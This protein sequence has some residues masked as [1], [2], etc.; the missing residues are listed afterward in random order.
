M[1]N[2]QAL[3]AIAPHAMTAAIKEPL[4]T[5]LKK[6]TKAGLDINEMLS[7]AHD[8]KYTKALKQY[9]AGQWTAPSEDFVR[10]MTGQVYDGRIIASVKEQFVD[11]VRRALPQFVS[12]RIS[13]R[14]KSALRQE[15]VA[16]EHEEAPETTEEAPPLDDGIVTTEEELEGFHVVRA[17]LREVVEVSRITHRDVKSYFGILLDDNNRKPICRLHFNTSQKYIGRFDAERKEERVPIGSVDDI[18]QNADALKTTIG[19]YEE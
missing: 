5:E 14:L 10:F 6:L 12:D 19:Y 16:A 3:L 2:H 7:A 15:V 13:D 11:I 9:L 8:L 4:V 17:I 1:I 18:Y